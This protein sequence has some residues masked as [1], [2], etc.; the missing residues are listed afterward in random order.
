MRERAIVARCE[1]VPQARKEMWELGTSSPVSND[2]GDLKIETK[3][4]RR[5]DR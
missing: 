3:R 2:I 4:C 5:R 1:L